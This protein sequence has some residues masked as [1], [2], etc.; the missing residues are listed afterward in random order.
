[1]D[2][3]ETK[4]D[5]IF[6]D[7]GWTALRVVAGAHTEDAKMLQKAATDIEKAADNGYYDDPEGCDL[8]KRI[9]AYYRK[10]AV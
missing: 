9:A 5:A 2:D 4:D 3:D 1:M 7:P 10:R 6:F 8:L